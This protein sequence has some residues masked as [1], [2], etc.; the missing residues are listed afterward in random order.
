MAH[1]PSAWIVKANDLQRMITAGISTALLDTFLSV[2]RV[3][4]GI[5]S[6]PYH[7]P[8]TGGEPWVIFTSYTD[9]TA[10]L[11]A[12]ITSGTL[13]GPYQGVIFDL[14]AWSNTPA[15]EQKAP[16]YYQAQAAKACA[17]VGL[18]IV[19]TPGMDL[20]PVISGGA[21][22]ASPA[23][24][25]SWNMAHDAAMVSDGLVIQ[26]QRYDRDTATY[27]SFVSEAASQA[28][29]AHPGVNVFA[30]LS[31]C[32]GGTPA[33]AAQLYAAYQQSNVYG[34]WLNVPVWSACPTG[35]AP[36]AIGFLQQVYGIS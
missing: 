33:T 32:A 20:I 36:A 13:P 15:A 25:M 3:G 18:P 24:Y 6:S 11:A 22:S 27:S 21:D 8:G 7:A 5:T 28:R 16:W 1:P 12:A 30:G 19:S 29:T 34:Y 23:T 10:G 26:A 31:S 14:E 35:N 17:T 2:A 4:Y 9:P